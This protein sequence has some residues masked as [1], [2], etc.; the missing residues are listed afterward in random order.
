MLPGQSGQRVL[1]RTL[2]GRKFHKVPLLFSLV[3]KAKIPTPSSLLIEQILDRQ[4]SIE[5]LRYQ[6]ELFWSRNRSEN[7]KFRLL[8]RA[9]A[10]TWFGQKRPSNRERFGNDLQKKCLVQI[11]IKF[12]LNV[13][14][15]FEG[16]NEPDKVE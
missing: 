15:K 11:V 8:A 16:I 13:Q 10:E 5:R 6:Q 14:F 9:C 3:R 2:V 4:R 1:L 7:S 12:I